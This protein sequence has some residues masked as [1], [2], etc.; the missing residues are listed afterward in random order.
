MKNG[1]DYVIVGAG[2]V[3]CV[4]GQAD[5]EAYR[6]SQ[7]AKWERDLFV[8]KK[9]LADAERGLQ[10]KETKRARDGVRIA[11]NKIQTYL[12]RL[13]DTRRVSPEERDRVSFQ[14]SIRGIIPPSARSSARPR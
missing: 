3:G 7:V 2:S 14:W 10:T 13:S 6:S 8:Q 9:R 12:D 4:G 5:I 11:K 1:Y